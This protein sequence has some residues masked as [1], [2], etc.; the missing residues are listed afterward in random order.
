ML[1][2]GVGSSDADALFGHALCGGGTA[3]NAAISIPTTATNWETGLPSI[4]RRKSV[5]AAWIAGG[6]A[7]SAALIEPA[8]TG[9]T[10]CNG[11][12]QEKC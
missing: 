7:F 5:D 6:D 12:Q 8:R 11:E 1:H 2:V 4:V 10:A 9:G 3:I